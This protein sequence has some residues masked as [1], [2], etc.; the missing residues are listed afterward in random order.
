MEQAIARLRELN[1]AIPRPIPRPT[2]EDVSRV[3]DSLN[4][5]LP[6]DFVKLQLAAGDVVFGT[7]EPVTLARETGHTYLVKVARDAWSS[8][9]PK[10]FLPICE[11]NGDYYCLAED[12]TVIFWSRQSV[13]NESWPSL[14]SWVIGVWVGENA[15]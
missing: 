6:V 14:E 8:G 13:S 10:N 11:S 7:L 2:M 4:V 3:E 12:G 15:L 1:E 5:K 9:L